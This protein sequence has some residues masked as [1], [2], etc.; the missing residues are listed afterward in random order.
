MSSDVDHEDGSIEPLR[1]EQRFNFASPWARFWAKTFDNFIYLFALATI[2]QFS[3]P[4][5]Y[6]SIVSANAY[7]LNFLLLPVAMVFD[8]I[9]QWRFGTSIGKL[10][11][12]IK[13]IRVQGIENGLEFAFMRNLTL[14]IYGLG[15]GFPFAFLFTGTNNYNA[16]KDKKLTRWDRNYGTRVIADGEN[17]YR[18]TAVAVLYISC[19]IFLQ[20][21]SEVAP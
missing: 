13:I 14:Y 12:G 17:I 19:V 6:D 16:L 5:L 4:S 15:I 7:A 11:I 1:P 20:Y 18:I 8:A 9:V 21:I 10:F 2:L 3:L